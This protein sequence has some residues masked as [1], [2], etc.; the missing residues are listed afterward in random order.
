[1]TTLFSKKIN[2]NNYKKYEKFIKIGDDKLWKS[3][4]KK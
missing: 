1:M 4:I 3:Y 2:K